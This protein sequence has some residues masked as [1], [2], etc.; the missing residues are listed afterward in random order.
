MILT[1]S[2][3]RNTIL[4]KYLL[5]KRKIIGQSNNFILDTLDFVCFYH[6]QKKS[7]TASH[8]LLTTPKLKISDLGVISPRSASGAI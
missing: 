1:Q 7:Y 6:L 4:R 2:M 8:I 3:F 5:G